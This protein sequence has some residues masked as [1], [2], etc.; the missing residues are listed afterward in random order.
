MLKVQ[1]AFNVTFMRTAD[2]TALQSAIAALPAPMA[3]DREVLSLRLNFALYYRD[4]PQAREL[5]QKMKGAEDNGYFA[6]AGIPVPIG[7]Y[8]ILLARFQ[9]EQPDPTS[10]F[11]KTREQLSQK[12]LK[13]PGNAQLLSEL[14]VVDA[15]LGNKEEA[16]REAKSA[17]EMLP[18]S[19][20]AVDG[21]SLVINLAAVYAWTNEIDLAFETL[22]SM[23]KTPSGIFYGQLKATHTGSPFGKILA[24]PI[25]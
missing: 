11:V 9:R 3:D 23:T 24:L 20:D 1:K 4:W 5:I 12:V 14:A 10:E 2:A 16:T 15:L 18:S 8:S 21:P 6:Y 13:S 25:C 7:C 19:K 17:V 22:G